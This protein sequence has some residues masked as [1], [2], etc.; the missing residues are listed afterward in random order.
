MT[1]CAGDEEGAPAPCGCTLNPRTP[2]QGIVEASAPD[3]V[4]TGE[5]SPMLETSPAAREIAP[6]P[7]VVPRARAAPLFVLFAAFLN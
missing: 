7:A 2:A 5:L 6:A 1:C 3:A 4:P